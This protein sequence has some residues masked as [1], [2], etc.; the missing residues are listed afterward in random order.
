[1]SGG[2]G[3]GDELGYDRVVQSYWD[4]SVSQRSRFWRTWAV[5]SGLLVECGLSGV[6]TWF[7]EDCG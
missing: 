3:V 4:P 7:L 2:K 6:N 5:L 1:M